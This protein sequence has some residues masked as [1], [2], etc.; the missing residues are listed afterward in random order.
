[1][2]L[3]TASKIQLWVNI[4][5]FVITLPISAILLVLMILEKP[6]DWLIDQKTNALFWIGNKLMLLSDEAKNGEIKNDY[7]LRNYTA[8]L[9][10]YLL[11]EEKKR[12][13]NG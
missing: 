5:L 12:N 1:M 10:Y 3:K 11:E 4:I 8:R 13:N 2:K 6:F 7:C 9:A